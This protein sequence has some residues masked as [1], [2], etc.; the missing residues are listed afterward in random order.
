M[1]HGLIQGRRK[2]QVEQGNLSLDEFHKFVFF[3]Q[4]YKTEITMRSFS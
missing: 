3:F 2:R 4:S 1:L